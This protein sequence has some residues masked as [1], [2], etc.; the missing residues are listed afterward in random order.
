MVT[1]LYGCY[2]T[3]RI[4]SRNIIKPLTQIWLADIR[5]PNLIFRKLIK[6]ENFSKVLTGYIIKANDRWRL[7]IILTFN[8]NIF[9]STKKRLSINFR[10]NRIDDSIGNF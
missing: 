4:C 3:C 6:N 8:F 7:H 1:V 2:R 9:E 5:V 10:V